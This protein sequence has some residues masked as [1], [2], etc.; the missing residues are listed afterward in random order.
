MTLW[1]VRKAT[2]QDVAYLAP[3]LRA[4]DTAECSAATGMSTYDAL[5]AGLRHAR[6]ILGQDEKPIAIF[7]VQPITDFTGAVWMACTPEL[8]QPPYVTEFIRQSRAM[9]DKLNEEFPLLCNAVDERNTLHIRW[10]EWCGFI[11]INRHQHYGHEKR[12]FLEFVRIIPH[13]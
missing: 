1:S 10:L 5:M 11:F 12:P 3:R 4:E 6:V 8:A 7:G 9:C 13:V 2:E